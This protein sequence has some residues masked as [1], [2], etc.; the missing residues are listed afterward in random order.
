[1]G[2]GFMNILQASFKDLHSIHHLQS[3]YL[4]NPTSLEQLQQDF[5]QENNTFLVAKQDGTDIVGFL[6][7]RKVDDEAEL[8]TIVVH[9]RFQRQGIGYEL[10]KRMMLALPEDCTIFLEVA[11]SN[12]GAQKFYESFGFFMVGKRERYYANDDALVMKCLGPI[13]RI[14]PIGQ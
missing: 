6:Q 1:M 5:T 9:Q 2:W 4:H 14:G 13:G 12:T 7:Y 8:I 3:Q 10:M 11:Q